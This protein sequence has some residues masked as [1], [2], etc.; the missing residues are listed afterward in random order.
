[1]PGVPLA[2]GAQGP[3]IHVQRTGKCAHPDTC[4]T[5]L[6]KYAWVDGHCEKGSEHCRYAHPGESQRLY[7]TSYNRFFR[8]RPCP[9]LL[10]GEFCQFGINCTYVHP[11]HEEG[12][13]GANGS[14]RQKATESAFT[15][16]AGPRAFGGG[17]SHRSPLSSGL[18][19]PRTSLS[20]TSLSPAPSSFASPLAGAAVDPAAH[21]LAHA[22]AQAAIAPYLAATAAA[23]AVAAHAAQQAAAHSGS[24]PSS[25]LFQPVAFA[26]YHA[27]SPISATP[28]SSADVSP[29]SSRSHSPVFGG[30]AQVAAAVDAVI[31][32]AHPL[33]QLLRPGAPSTAPA[34][35]LSGI[36]AAMRELAGF[37]AAA[38]APT[39]PLRGA[40]PLL[41]AAAD[42]AQ[43]AYTL[44]KR[45]TTQTL[46]LLSAA[47]HSA[48][49]AAS[50]LRAGALPVL[51]AA[52]DAAGAR[53]APVMRTAAPAV[54]ELAAAI[55][56]RQRQVAA[57]AAL[58]RALVGPH[59]AV[60]AAVSSAMADAVLPPLRAAAREPLEVT[61]SSAF[62]RVSGAAA[63]EALPHTEAA[64]ALCD[65]LEAAPAGAPVAFFLVF[66]LLPKLAYRAF[67]ARVG[68]AAAAALGERRVRLVAV[69]P[70]PGPADEGAA[71]AL[72]ALPPHAAVSLD[73]FLAGLPSDPS[74]GGRLRGAELGAIG[75]R[76]PPA[77]PAVPRGESPPEHASPPPLALG[78]NPFLSGGSPPFGP[79]AEAAPQLAQ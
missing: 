9:K 72:S 32:R 46:A 39:L 27:P 11:E 62:F 20:P 63:S 31:E 44:A 70:G 42:L 2:H 4:K 26:A 54:E 43:V 36:R 71:A 3:C 56:A 55:E 68:A 74:W 48:R 75:R 6:C 14:P 19:S 77:T 50:A 35:S 22:A 64:R 61:F 58:V 23:H 24:G 45:S 69:L 47:R 73:G 66:P 40:A 7:I 8:T 79:L 41:R 29:G 1:M 17:L 37:L 34:A 78:K 38:S 49:E 13:A 51:E 18:D 67:L 53:L 60:C 65:A 30:P 52:A 33:L 76:T 28:P 15:S 5:I 59:S 10:R 16:P 57:E 12:S 21:Q 25:P